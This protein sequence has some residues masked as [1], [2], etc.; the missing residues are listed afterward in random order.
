M[1]LHLLCAVCHALPRVVY[2]VP[3]STT[4]SVP[5]VMLYHVPCIV[6]RHVV[7]YVMCCVSH[8]TVR[9]VLCVMLLRTQCAVCHVV[10]YAMYRVSRCTVSN[11]PHVTLCHA[12]LGSPQRGAAP[13]RGATQPPAEEAGDVAQHRTQAGSRQ[14]GG[15]GRG[16]GDARGRGSEVQ[17]R[18]SRKEG[19]KCADRGR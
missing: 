14:G 5:C 9:N 10:Q 8:C 13:H 15:G 7:P 11:V 12:P 2:R 3:C 19:I 16:K 6:V 4:C 18:N 17:A 1:L